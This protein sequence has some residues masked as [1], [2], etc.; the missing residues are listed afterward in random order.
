MGHW[1]F[2]KLG[3]TPVYVSTVNPETRVKVATNLLRDYGFFN[4]SVSYSVDTLKNPRKAKLNYEINMANPY[5][6][7]GSKERLPE[8]KNS[9][10]SSGT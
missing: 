9:K 3:S 6:L 10:L 8:L 4:G 5:Y 1:I 7:V 2:N